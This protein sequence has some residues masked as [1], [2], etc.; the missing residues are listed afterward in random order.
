MAIYWTHYNALR[1]RA[2]TLKPEARLAH[3]FSATHD[4]IVSLR[5]NPG[6]RLSI[7]DFD[8]FCLN[9]SIYRRGQRK[10]I[11]NA[12]VTAF[13]V[14]RFAVARPLHSAPTLHA[15]GENRRTGGSFRNA[16]DLTKEEL[17][18]VAYRTDRIV[19]D[20]R[21]RFSLGSDAAKPTEA[22]LAR[23]ISKSLVEH[24]LASLDTWR[25][26]LSESGLERSLT[27]EL[28]RQNEVAGL[29]GHK[30]RRSRLPFAAKRSAWLRSRRVCRGFIWRPRT[31]GT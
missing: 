22:D 25:R 27:Y 13:S 20:L 26:L 11:H 14:H 3:S 12:Q 18:K 4:L 9:G 28:R 5:E 10:P 15:S 7:S 23:S 6:E 21:S 24:G 30:R 1:P 16:A 17:R 19:A 2:R 31:G 29:S 8:A